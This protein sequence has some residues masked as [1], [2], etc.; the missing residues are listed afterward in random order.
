MENLDE[1]GTLLDIGGNVG[2][3]SLVALAANRKVITIEADLNNAN[4]IR[5]SVCINNF[6]ALSTIYAEPLSKKSEKCVTVSAIA[7]PRD[8]FLVCPEEKVKELQHTAKALGGSSEW[9]KKGGLTYTVYVNTIFH[10][11]FVVLYL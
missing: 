8:Y 5:A 9:G 3:H 4:L 1:R 10:I 11:Y 2:W 6:D 7:N